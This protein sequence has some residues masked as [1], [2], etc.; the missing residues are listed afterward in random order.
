MLPYQNCVSLS[1]QITDRHV[2]LFSSHSAVKVIMFLV[3]LILGMFKEEAIPIKNI[4]S[5]IMGS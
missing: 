4:K 5:Q 1:S 3:D 2:V